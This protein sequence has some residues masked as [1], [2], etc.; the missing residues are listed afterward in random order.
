MKFL[1]T[2]IFL[3]LTIGA[4]SQANT[5][6]ADMDPICTDAG[7]NFTAQANGANVI[8]SE[9][10]N[11]YQCLGYSP[12]PTWYYLEIGTAGNIDMSLTAPSDIDF[13]IWGPYTD[14]ATAQGECG[15][16]GNGGAGQNVIDC[17]Y[18]GTNMETPSIP[19]AQV[20]EVYVMLITNYANN[21]QNLSLTQTGGTG[22]TD[23]TIIPP[24]QSNAGTF[25]YY[26]NGIA[27]TN[28]GIVLCDGDEV[29]IVTNSDYILPNDT[30]A[31]NYESALMFM[32]YDAPP[33][34]ADPN[35]DPAFLGTYFADSIFNDVNNPASPIVSGPGYGTYYLVPVSGDD[36]AYNG[37]PNGGVDY[38]KDG[39]GCFDLGD[40]VEVTYLPPIDISSDVSCDGTVAGNGIE[41]T[42][43]GGYPE[44]LGGN[45][46][47]TNGGDGSLSSNS[48]PFNG[49]VTVTGL[50]NGEI[51]KIYVSDANNCMDSLQVVFSAP[52]FSI[53]TTAATDCGTTAIDNGGA[54]VN[55]NNGSGNGPGYDITINGNTTSGVTTESVSNLAAGTNVSVVVADVEGCAASDN[56]TVGSQGVSINES[57]INIQDL[58]CGGADDGSISVDIDVTG[59]SETIADF[60]VTD[61]NSNTS[62]ENAAIGQSSYTYSATGLEAGTYTLTIEATNGCVFE[63]QYTVNEP[64]PVDV[65]VVSFSEPQ[66]HDGND[67]SIDVNVT[68]GSSPYS[69]SWTGGITASSE[70]LDQLESGTYQLIVTDDNGC[71]DTVTQVLDNPDPFTAD[72]TTKDPTC[73]GYEDGVA[74]VTNLQGNQGQ[75]TYVWSTDNPNPSSVSNVNNLVPGTHTVQLFDENG[76][77]VIIEFDIFEVPPFVI[78]NIDSTASK[79]R[80]NG[81]YPGTGQVSVNVGGSNGGISIMWYG[82]GDTTNTPTWGNRTPGLYTYVATDSKGCE[83][84]GTVYVDSINPVA[85]FTVDPNQGVAPLDVDFENTSSNIDPTN[86][87]YSW[88]PGFGSF[89]STE[90]YNYA[91]DTTY[92][93]GGIYTAILV[94]TNEYG[95]KDSVSKEIEV[96]TPL[97]YT[98][99]NIFT[100]N[101]DEVNDYFYI[102]GQGITENN[103]SMVIYNRWGELLYETN[104]PG[105]TNG[106]DGNNKKGKPL[107]EGVY[108]YMY[109]LESEEGEVVKG[110]GFFHLVR[111]GG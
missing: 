2:S 71:E 93:E 33:T 41:F 20:G 78:N 46:N 83:L 90:D 43:A 15:N 14:L 47:I 42:I 10:G 69:Y 80:S 17:S 54:T 11:N 60:T 109:Q 79:C 110:Q 40:E 85:D 73:N 84:T 94:V 58:T 5:N 77:D 13:I 44:I 70:D 56:A 49:T 108:K 101:G 4:F 51:A 102:S 55:V 8:T 74:S 52:T 57:N 81:N 37:N 92:T 99:P 1:F 86:A 104:L 62:T 107:P 96:F 29:E 97:E 76:C 95:C 36:G 75:V 105:Q 30:I 12:N 66:C 89:N 98:A 48:A 68:G 50:A 111:K 19:N 91:P 72:I 82:N 18:S 45:Y 16:L 106:W 31:G 103:Y 9:P 3:G 34:N 32:L 59:G 22:E 64:T 100:P 21:V 67:G 87:S 53:N 39:N 65:N 63:F 61:P 28:N 26:K 88:D 25:S 6:C 35:T 7:L 24:C 38:D 23:C 27:T